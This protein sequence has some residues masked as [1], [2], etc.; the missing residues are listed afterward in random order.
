MTRYY[1]SS[2]IIIMD[3]SIMSIIDKVW[4]RAEREEKRS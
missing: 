2:E 1:I 3:I 4:F